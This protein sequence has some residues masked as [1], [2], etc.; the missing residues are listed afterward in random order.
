MCKGGKKWGSC[1][2]SHFS[3]LTTSNVKYRLSAKPAESNPG[4]IFAELAGTEMVNRFMPAPNLLYKPLLLPRHLEGKQD[5]RLFDPSTFA[6]LLIRFR[7]IPR[8]LCF[9]VQSILLYIAG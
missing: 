5:Q 3:C 6:G 1:V 9:Q 2:I 7:L 4:P 8:R